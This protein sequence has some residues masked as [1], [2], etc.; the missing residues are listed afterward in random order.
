[1]QQTPNLNL[2]KP[3]GTDVVDIADLNANM[4]IVDGKL[5]TNGH[6][7]SGTAGNGPKITSGGLA[8]GAATDSIIGSRTAI[9]STAPTSLT[10]SLTTL[11]NGIF[12][13]LKSI[14][15]KA[16]GYTAPATTLE[17]ANTHMTAATGAHGA[18]S[19][20]TANAI[21]QRDASGNFIAGSI[22]AS[23][24]G[25][26]ATATILQTA[27]NINGVAF[28]GG[29]DITIPVGGFGVQGSFKN[30]KITNGGTPYTQIAVTADQVVLF[31]AS[32]LAYLAVSPSIIIS[33]GTS[34]ANGLDTGPV[35]NSTWYSVWL[36][37]NG[38]SVSGLLSASAT[39]PTMP[40]GY[41]HK[42]RLGWIRTNAS[43]NLYRTLQYGRKVQYIVDGTILTAPVTMATGTATAWTAVA[44]A[45]FV[46]S[47][48]MAIRV[49]IVGNAYSGTLFAVAPNNNYN[50]TNA[51]IYFRNDVP[52]GVAPLLT[53]DIILE[54]ANVYWGCN[55]PANTGAL[56]CYGWEDNL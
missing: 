7:H 8:A 44:V 14:T 6:D 9:D 47:T 34:G 38:T 19:A 17:A 18:T 13:M 27:R 10:G 37:Y 55:V 52:N 2:N 53:E 28:N 45:S 24:N 54:S 3:D 29:A 16:N 56:Y 43:G 51:P 4:D 23:L 35:A 5:G 31:N 21:V 12:Y 42:A 20:S 15:G 36:I 25:N 39:T 26:A 50:V 48:A 40:S 49:G 22:T 46:P 1:M 30:L 11:L 33:T 41:T 32:N